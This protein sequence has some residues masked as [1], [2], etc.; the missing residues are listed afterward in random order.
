MSNNS[1]LDLSETCFHDQLF[2]RGEAFNP[3]PTTIDHLPITGIDPI[4]DDDIGQLHL[5]LKHGGFAPTRIIKILRIDQA[6]D[7]AEIDLVGEI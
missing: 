5:I 7:V 2:W 3:L 4:Q 6:D 1:G